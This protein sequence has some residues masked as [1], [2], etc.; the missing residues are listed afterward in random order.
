MMRGLI[1]SGCVLLP[2]VGLALAQDLPK[3]GSVSDVTLSVVGDASGL[4]QY[5]ATIG[6][7][8]KQA[9]IDGWPSDAPEP[10]RYILTV[11]INHAGYLESMLGDEFVP[12]IASPHSDL[13]ARTGNRDP[14]RVRRNAQ[15]TA[16]SRAVEKVFAGLPPAP[17]GD[18]SHPIIV[19]VAFVF[20][21]GRPQL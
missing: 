18:Y 10:G 19:K 4:D 8:I 1:R 21:I 12:T 16:T 2:L 9:W 13:L 5:I 11:R 15:I 14:A 6:R 7:G 20:G 3:P 17:P